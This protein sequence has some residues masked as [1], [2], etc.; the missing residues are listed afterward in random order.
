[1][2]FNVTRWCA[3]IPTRLQSWNWGST[4]QCSCACSI[5]SGPP[6]PVSRLELLVANILEF[7][8]F[9]KS[10]GHRLNMLAVTCVNLCFYRVGP[11]D[12][13][14]DSYAKTSHTSPLRVQVYLW[15]AV[16]SEDVSRQPCALVLCEEGWRDSGRQPGDSYQQVPPKQG[17]KLFHSVII[18]ISS[19]S[20]SWIP[21]YKTETALILFTL[22]ASLYMRVMHRQRLS[23]RHTC[24]TYMDN[25]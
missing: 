24:E 12:R 13:Q 22:R 5:F 18:Y 21:N 16:V 9:S 17:T 15:D 25:N 3:T 11:T 23:H 4:R 7:A 10:L 19:C 20:L 6:I 14:T 8:L 1:M 2:S